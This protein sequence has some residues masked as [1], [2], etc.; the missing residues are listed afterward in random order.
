M[1]EPFDYLNS[2]MVNNTYL[3]NDSQDE[4][5]YPAFFVN[6]GLSQHIDCVMAANEMNINSH[7][8]NKLQYDFLFHAIRKMKRK[9]GKWAKRLDDDLIKALSKYY[10]VGYRRAKEYAYLM[11]DDQKKVIME[12]MKS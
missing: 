8:D 7:L 6:R 2:I 10:N 4:K 9:Y 5:D 12:K 11:N 3:M 1:T